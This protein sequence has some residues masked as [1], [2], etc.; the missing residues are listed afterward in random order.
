MDLIEA[1][2]VGN[3]EEVKRLVE[4]GADIHAEALTWAAE[5]GRLEVVRYFNR[6]WSRCSY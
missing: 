3:L 1:C 6:G 5:Y 2:K 4:A